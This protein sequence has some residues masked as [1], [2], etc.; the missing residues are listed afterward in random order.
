MKK[1][2][3]ATSWNSLGR[4]YRAAPPLLSLHTTEQ[5]WPARERLQVCNSLEECFFFFFFFLLMRLFIASQYSGNGEV[6]KTRGRN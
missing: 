2:D 1:W 3:A 4:V 5:T 6:E